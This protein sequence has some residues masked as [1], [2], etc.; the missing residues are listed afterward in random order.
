MLR[1]FGLSALLWLGQAVGV[2]SQLFPLE[3][4]GSTGSGC[5]AEAIDIGIKSLLRS[6]TIIIVTIIA[7][8]TTITTIVPIL[9][10]SC[11]LSYIEPAE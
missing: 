3:S 9:R 4:N 5:A 8:I 2:S 10:L 1:V 11:A 6:P 7:T